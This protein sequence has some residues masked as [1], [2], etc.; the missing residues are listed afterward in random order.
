[1]KRPLNTGIALI[2]GGLMGCGPGNLAPSL[3]S[4]IL[5]SDEIATVHFLNVSASES[6]TVYAEYG[7][8]E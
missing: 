3:S 7:Q 2:V 1:M 6:G 8:E 4:S 5:A